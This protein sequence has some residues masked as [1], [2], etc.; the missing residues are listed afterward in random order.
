M[1]RE[2]T[3]AVVIG[4]GVVGLACARALAQSGIETI[5]IEQHGGIGQETSSRN[6]EVIHAGIYYPAGSLKSRL[7]TEGRVRLYEFCEARGI[8]FKRCGKLV[9]ATQ[10]SHE[11]KLEQLQRHA[12]ENGVADTVVIPARQAISM[13]PQLKCSAALY[14]PS[15]GIIDSHALMLALLGDAEAGGASLALHSQILAGR[16]ESDTIQLHVRC[17]D[18]DMLISS[19]IVINAAGLW[20]PGLARRLEGLSGNAIPHTWLAKGNYYS[21]SGRAPFSRLIYPVPEP[22]G[23]GVHLTLDMGGQARFGPDVQWVD[24][25]DY[26]VDPARSRGFYAEIRKYWPSLSEG[27]LAPAYCGIRP[28]LSGPG[29]AAA[30]FW[31]QHC[32]KHGMPGLINLFGIESPGLTSCL[33]IAD[34]VCRLLALKPS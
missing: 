17:G 33:A 14:S 24:A 11:Q 5:I 30:D 32:D 7:C 4:A 3:G 12:I 8:P 6:S 28:K 27:A 13:E 22:G 16:K 1:Q 10:D 18:E 15:T 20:A 23:L 21:L 2:H 25:I 9:V 26:S 29:D 19:G 31:I 34:E